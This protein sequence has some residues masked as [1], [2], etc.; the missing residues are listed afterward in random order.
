MFCRFV[1]ACSVASVLIAIGAVMSLLL[2]FPP[3]GAWMVS[4][5][6]CFVPV[7]WGLWAMLTPSRWVPRRFSAWGAILGLA[8]GIVAGPLLNIPLRVGA[9]GG[10]RW[11]APIAGPI[12]Y[13]LIWLLVGVAYRSLHVTGHSG[14]ASAGSAGS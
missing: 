2:R 10:V 1:A 6:W 11:I 5:A 13:Y 3:Q 12:F 14:T 8:A 7:A 9:P 4:T